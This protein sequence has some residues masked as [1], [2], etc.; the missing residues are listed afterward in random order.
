MAERMTLILDAFDRRS[1]R[2]NLQE[3]AGLTRL[4][5]STAHRILEQLVNLHW[6]DHTALGYTLGRRALG[7]GGDGGL[8]SEIRRAAA[9]HL[10]ELQLRTGMAVHLAVPEGSEEVYLDKIGDRF[11]AAMA[12]RVGGRQPI[13]FTTGGRAMLAMLQP[14]H[15]DALVRDNLASPESAR[16]WT[17]DG[18]HRELGHIRKHR[19]L[20]I[21]RTGVL[22]K[23]FTSAAMAVRGPEGP[24][25]AISVCPQSRQ[26]PLE[27]VAPLIAET[28][29]RTTAD[30]FG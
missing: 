1:T 20:S 4:P 30:L 2:L 24:V 26:A 12:S 25:A 28:V 21:D 23:N 16:G 22:S 17:L 9:Q 27:R 7:L 10:H 29:R 13:H 18:L 19:G 5:R 11:A 6:L 14:E 15:A 8:Q 3:V